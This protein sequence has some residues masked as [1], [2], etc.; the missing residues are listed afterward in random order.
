MATELCLVGLNGFDIVFHLSTIGAP[1]TDDPSHTP[2]V[3][4]CHVVE[5]AGE[6]GEGDQSCLS[7]LEPI[8]DPHQCGFPITFDSERR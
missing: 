6:R 8:I 5:E 4:V 2:A 7:I 1:K 3:Y